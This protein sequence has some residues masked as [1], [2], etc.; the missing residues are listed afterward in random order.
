MDLPP[1]PAPPAVSVVVIFLDEETF[2]AEAVESVLAQTYR[3]WELLLVDDGSTDRSTALAQRYADRFPGRV[4]YLEHPGHENR[5]MSATRNLGVA[6]ARGRYVAFLDADDVW[7]P[8]KLAEQVAIFETHPELGM[9]CGASEYWWSWGDPERDDVVVP[10]GGRQDAVSRPPELSLALYPLGEGAAPCPSG[11][12][13][14][15]DVVEAVGGFV[16]H[17]RGPYQLY[18]DQA[19]L[20]KV[21]LSTPI[22][23]ASGCWDRYRQ[24]PDSCV[25]EV[26]KAGKYDEV[27]RFFLEWLEGYL[28]AQPSPHPDVADALR[29]ALGPYRHPR[30]TRV[31]RAFRR[32]T[33]G[34][35][36]W[37]AA[38][39]S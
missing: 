38:L 3:D 13:L 34:L 22:Y 17:F 30:R 6:N 36:R 37:S 9:V 28:A 26:T 39:F 33:R 4:R 27:R 35:T 14:R 25:A 2:L 15:R 32:L 10:V 21:Y 7:R 23:V 20:A 11:L 12:V 24:H 1:D 8:E 5:G 18:E 19:F 31:G 29:R 16:E